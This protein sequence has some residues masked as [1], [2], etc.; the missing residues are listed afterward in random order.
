[1]YWNTFYWTWTLLLSAYGTKHVETLLVNSKTMIKAVLTVLATVVAA[2]AYLVLV[3]K[4]SAIDW[5]NMPNE[6][7]ATVS[8]KIFTT[9]DGRRF[10]YFE[11]GA[12]IDEARESIL[13]IHGTAMTGHFYT[14]YADSFKKNNLHVV[15]F[16]QPGQGYSDSYPTHPT[17]KKYV[18]SDIM[19]LIEHVFPNNKPFSVIGY[20]F[21]GSMA[22]YI[23]THVDHVKHVGLFSSMAPLNPYNVNATEMNKALELGRGL[24]ASPTKTKLFAF[25]TKVIINYFMDALWSPNERSTKDKASA[26]GRELFAKDLRRGVTHGSDGLIFA[27]NMMG[28]DWDVDFDK[29]SEKD[30]LITSSTLDD[31]CA[32]ALQQFL[33]EKIKNHRFLQLEGAHPD[34]ADQFDQIVLKLVFV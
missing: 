31:R 33:K 2:L 26:Y 25:T 12:S 30:V 19:P 27:V 14:Q 22:A 34:V 16:S 6:S 1:M 3:P 23:G 21:A 15:T 13:I 24:T 10:E 29:L 8:H 9:P 5:N 28:S 20:S 17:V 18:E 4:N 7:N 11:L 32:P